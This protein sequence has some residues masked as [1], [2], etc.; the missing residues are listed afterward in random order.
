MIVKEGLFTGPVSCKY[1]LARS[2]VPERYGKH[3]IQPGREVIP[4]IFVEMDY[5][6]GVALRPEAVSAP[7]ELGAQLLEV[8]DL[9]VRHHYYTTVLVGHGLAPGLGKI[10]DAQP[11]M[12]QADGGTPAA[13]LAI[14]ALADVKACIV[15]TPVLQGVS[16]LD[17]QVLLY[18][19][20]LELKNAAETAHGSL[21]HSS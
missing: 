3:P 7:N 16:H 2:G 12:A 5:D 11:A 8:I 20:A 4:M 19:G 1:Q 6:F 10:D 14:T 17:E 15:R 13:S 9:A 21:F 18:R